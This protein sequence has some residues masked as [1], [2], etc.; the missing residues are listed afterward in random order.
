MPFVSA[1]GFLLGR[2][3][4]EVAENASKKKRESLLDKLKCVSSTGRLSVLEVETLAGTCYDNA[5]PL[6]WRLLKSCWVKVMSERHT[7][8]CPGRS[9]T[10]WE[11]IGF[12][13][14]DPVT[15]LRGS[16]ILG[17]LHLLH[18]AGHYPKTTQAAFLISRS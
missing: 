16:G 9:G 4:R 1:Y 3:Q 12:Q 15:D 13:G 10:H 7:E 8:P 11:L 17:L 18:L 5:D 6:H 14:I 2:A